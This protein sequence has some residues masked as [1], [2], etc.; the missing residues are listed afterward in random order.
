MQQALRPYAD[1][2]DQFWE[3]RLLAR[4]GVGVNHVSPWPRKQF[5]THAPVMTAYKHLPKAI[6]ARLF[7]FGFVRNPWDMLVSRYHYI[8]KQKGHRWHRWVIDHSFEEFVRR[9]VTRRSIDQ[10]SFLAD[11]RGEI[12]VDYVGRF[13]RLHHDFAH[14]CQT[15]RIDAP[16]PH[17]NASGQRDYRAYYDRSLARLVA[18]HCKR[19]LD[20]FGYLFEE[21]STTQAA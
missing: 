5:R 19:D 17:C 16:L 21:T 20:R 3:N 12:L 18:A 13:E 9:T 7:K 1:H 15:L 4:L 14:V 8:A 10:T 11:A 2:P 6:F